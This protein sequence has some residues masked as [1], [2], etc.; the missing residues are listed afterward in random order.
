MR[1]GP[2]PS[3]VRHCH[4]IAAVQSTAHTTAYLIAYPTTYRMTYLK[5]QSTAQSMIP[6]F[7]SPSVSF[8]GLRRSMKLA[9]WPICVVDVEPVPVCVPVWVPV[10][11]PAPEPTPEPAPEPEATP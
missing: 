2:V 6:F 10:P 5:T 9:F 1:P 3:R 8:M 4:L 11:E 7:P